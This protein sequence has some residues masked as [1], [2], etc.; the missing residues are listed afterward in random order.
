MS[1]W[2]AEG[3]SGGKH[4]FCGFGQG[5]SITLLLPV[6]KAGSVRLNLYATRSFDFGIIQ[7]FLD[8]K[9]IGQA[10]DAYSPMV[11]PTGCIALGTVELEK[12]DHRLLFDV[13]GKN[14]ASKGFRFGVDCVE[15][16]R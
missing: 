1:P 9:Q 7:V 16:V 12:G 6:E 5:G 13:V 14:S 2:G 8:G 4:L 3:W 10:L 11:V 15:L